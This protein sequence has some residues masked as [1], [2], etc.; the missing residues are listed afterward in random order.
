[1][2]VLVTGAS[3]FLGSHICATLVEEGCEV[4]GASRGKGF[5]SEIPQVD[6]RYLN[7]TEPSSFEDIDFSEFDAVVHNAG[8]TFTTNSSR[9]LTVNFIGTRLLVHRLQEVGFRGK[10]LYISSLAVHLLARRYKLREVV[11]DEDIGGG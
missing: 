5:L 9:Y 11:K 1:M 10:F 8:I 3:G 2:K 6:W 4:V 7:L